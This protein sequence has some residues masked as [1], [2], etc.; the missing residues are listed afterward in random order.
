M[1]AVRVYIVS[2]N[3]KVGVLCYRRSRLINFV[4]D[5]KLTE[6]FDKLIDCSKSCKSKFLKLFQN[7]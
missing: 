6:M 2:Y 3:N 4:Q 1:C 7:M 5:E